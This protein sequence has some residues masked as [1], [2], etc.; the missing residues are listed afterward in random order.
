MRWSS[1]SKILLEEIVRKI[2]TVVTDF[3]VK[4][5]V[6]KVLINE[7]DEFAGYSTTYEVLGES[8]AYDYA[9]KQIFGDDEDEDDKYYDDDEDL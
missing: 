5:E 7:F 3:D 4:Q 8:D 9:F 6:F 2:D 1:S